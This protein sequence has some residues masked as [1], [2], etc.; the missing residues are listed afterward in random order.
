MKTTSM[1]LAATVAAIVAAGVPSSASAA[2]TGAPS[3][4]VSFNFRW[5]PE[6]HPASFLSSAHFSP[7]NVAA[8][9]EAYTMW[10]P[11][12]Y[13]TP[14]MKDV[15]ET[16][17]T[18]ALR[19]SLSAYEAAGHVSSWGSG[20][21]RALPPVTTETITVRVN[22]TS[23]ASLLSGSSMLAPSPDWFV[24]MSRVQLCNGTTWL[25]STSGG[26]GL[27]DAGTDSG[28]TLTAADLVTEPPTVIRPFRLG[29]YPQLGQEFGTWVAEQV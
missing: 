11:A 24:G 6:T 18:L 2:C 4:R 15:A 27:W 8:H 9:T 20:A 22:G 28:T 17:S 14:G 5:T 16:G 23:G 19:T 7:I 3:Y 13:A 21:P 25:T 10:L 26:L 29:E 12:G 1:F